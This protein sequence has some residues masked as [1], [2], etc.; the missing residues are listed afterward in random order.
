MD[1]LNGDN[2]LDILSHICVRDHNDSVTR[3]MLKIRVKLTEKPTEKVKI[4][5]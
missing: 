4:Y 3:Q 5:L 1:G 2:G